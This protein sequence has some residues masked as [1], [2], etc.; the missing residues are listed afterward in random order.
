MFYQEHGKRFRRKHLES[1][2][3]V[4][5]EKGD[6]EA[7]SRIC[8]IIQREHQ[9]NFWRRLNFVTGKKRTWRATT[10]QVQDQRCTIVK[11]NTQDSVEQSIFQEVYEKRYTLAG[12]APICNGTIFGE[13]G[14]TANT[15]A[16]RAV[17]DGTYVAPA[18]SD[19]AT[20]ELFAEIAA[21]R[22]L[23]PKNTVSAVI[24]PE[25]WSQY[26]MTVNEETSSSESG[27][28]FGHYIVGG[29]SNII[30]HYH[31]ARVSVTLAHAIVLEW[32]SRGLSV[33]LEKTLGVTLVT[34]LRAILLMEEDFNTTNKIIYGSRMINTARRHHLIPEEIFSKK[35]KRPTMEPCVSHCS[36]T[37]HTRQEY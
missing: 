27:L 18:D 34:K 35:I 11:C 26:W 31:T 20:S 14:Y 3:K 12:E 23:I 5:E 4:A 37:L 32:W 9:Q 33:M 30:N 36:T 2:K 1:Q 6:K 19:M 13:F 29:Q 28:H 22:R 8:T 7:F 16:S 25:Q 10:I 17:L 24:T 21:I 15:P